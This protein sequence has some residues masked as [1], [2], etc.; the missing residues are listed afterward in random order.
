MEILITK[1]GESI[2]SRGALIYWIGK[3]SA[4][5]MTKF[6]IPAIGIFLKFYRYFYQYITQALI[7]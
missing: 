1:F 7:G 5:D 3:I 6:S 4:A 2:L